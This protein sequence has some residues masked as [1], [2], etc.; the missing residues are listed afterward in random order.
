M[1]GL[2][3]FFFGLYILIIALLINARIVM[4]HERKTPANLLTLFIAINLMAHLI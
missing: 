4:K 2:L 1:V 3:A